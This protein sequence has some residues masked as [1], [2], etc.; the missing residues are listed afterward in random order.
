[1]YVSCYYF[2]GGIGVNKILKLSFCGAALCFLIE[3]GSR[4][5]ILLE[6]RRHIK[7]YKIR[8]LLNNILKII[9]ATLSLMVFMNFFYSD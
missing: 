9:P 3:L 6:K 1:M 4:F 8:F 7:T 2:L 5:L